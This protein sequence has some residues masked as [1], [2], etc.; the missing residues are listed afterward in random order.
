M[1]HGIGVFSLRMH[2]HLFEDAIFACHVKVMATMFYLYCIYV[3]MLASVFLVIL[4]DNLAWGHGMLPATVANSHSLL[5]QNDHSVN[6]ALKN[7][8]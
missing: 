1:I 3:C 8:L 6:R 5:F 2:S 7:C 4:S